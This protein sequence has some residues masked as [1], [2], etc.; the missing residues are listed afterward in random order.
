MCSEA[1]LF[2]GVKTEERIR[3]EKMGEK[4]RKQN[5]DMQNREK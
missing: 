5:K 4:N 2:N 1:V 3:E